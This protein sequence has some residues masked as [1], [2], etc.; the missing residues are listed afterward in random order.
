MSSCRSTGRGCI[1][2][3]TELG[4]GV[5]QDEVGAEYITIMTPRLLVVC[6][7]LTSQSCLRILSKTPQFSVLGLCVLLEHR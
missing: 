7:I 2:S 6:P 3:A 4:A 1:F 5:A